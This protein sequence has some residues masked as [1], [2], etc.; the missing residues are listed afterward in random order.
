MTRNLYLGADIFR[1]VT[2]LIDQDPLAIPET[3][4]EI[5]QTMQYTD[6]TERTEAIADEIQRYRPDLVGLQEV[7]TIRRQTPGDFLLGVIEPNATE[8][9][10]D[11]LDILTSALAA[12]DL[13]Y[14]V[15]VVVINA[16]VELPMLTGID[17]DGNPAFDDVRL[18]DHDVILVRG[19]VEISHPFTCNYT[20]SIGVPLGEDLVY[21]F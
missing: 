8:T 13:D 1:I 11:Y 9:V 7:T 17:P 16:D 10:Y 4:A 12:R 5:Y 3:V 19:D 18:T 2:A 15:A 21:R 6:F 20:T 14:R